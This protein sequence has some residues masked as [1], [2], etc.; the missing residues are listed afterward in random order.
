MGRFDPALGPEVSA[1][2]LPGSQ[3]LLFQVLVRQIGVALGVNE[4]FWKKLSC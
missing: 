4:K 2:L 1:H 3:H